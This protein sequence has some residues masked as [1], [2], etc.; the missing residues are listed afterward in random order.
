MRRFQSRQTADNVGPVADGRS[1]LAPPFSPEVAELSAHVPMIVGHT[2]NEGGGLNSFSVAREAWTDADVRRELAAQPTPI[3][4]SIVDAL[5]EAYPDAHPVELFVHATT[6][7]GWRRDAIELAT[8]KVAMRSAPV[9]L[10]TFAWKTQMVD[11]RPRAFHRSEIPFVFFNTDRA[12]NQTGGTDEARALAARVSDAWIAFAR[13]G[14]P[15]HPGLPTWPAF[16]PDRVETM[17]FDNNCAVRS[18]H[19]RRARLSVVS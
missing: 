3:S 2:L 10:Y 19:D 8:R 17:F 18:D 9:F 6:G 14:N 12:A 11:G 16:T 15:N 7:L 13:T 5:R 1:V 4:A